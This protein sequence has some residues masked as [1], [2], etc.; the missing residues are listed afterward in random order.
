MW[1]DVMTSLAEAGYHC[2]APDQRGYSPGA[3]PSGVDFYSFEE[4]AADALALGRSMGERFHLVGHDWGAIVGWLTLAT[5][6]SPIATWTSMSIPH[7]TAW[8]RAVYEDPAMQVYRDRLLGT[9]LQEG[10]GEASITPDWL[11]TIWASKPK[12]RAEAEI[13][14]LSEPGAITAALSWYRSSRGHRRV[15]E[16]FTIPAITTPTLHICSISEAEGRAVQEA[17][18]LMA[19]E[20]RV[21]ALEGTHFIVDDQPRRVAEETIAHLRAHPIR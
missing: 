14:R 9:W 4:L 7:Y 2:L 13:E 15:L 6:P 1:T 11:R 10:A 21:A 8:A 19:G 12:D 3:R 5:D 17:A 18:P 20:Y 16:D